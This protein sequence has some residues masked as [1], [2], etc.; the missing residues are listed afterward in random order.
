[1]SENQ[2]EKQ[3]QENSKGVYSRRKRQSYPQKKSSGDLIKSLKKGLI[4]GF[5]V[6]K[7]GLNITGL[8]TK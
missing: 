2:K 7:T 4:A 5:P 1:V 3:E 6:N 8:N